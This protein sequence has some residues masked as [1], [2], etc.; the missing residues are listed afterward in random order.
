MDKIYDQLKD[1][2]VAAVVIYA[3]S[4]GAYADADHETQLKTSEL[5]D[6]YIKGALISLGDGGF[7][8]PF[9]YSESEGIGS[10]SYIVANATTATSADI[11]TLEA[12]ADEA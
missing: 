9:G 10:V 8:S 2:H 4:G 5:K 1:V 11:A 7:V 6:A 3:Y 12:V